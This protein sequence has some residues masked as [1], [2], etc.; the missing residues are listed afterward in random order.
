MSELDTLHRRLVRAERNVRRLGALLLLGTAT[1]LLGALQ[2]QDDVLRARG[3]IITD[4]DGRERIVLGAPMQAASGNEKLVDAVGIA[5]LDSLGRLHVAMGANPPLVLDGGAI[6]TR[7]ATQAGMTFYDPR[8]G[9]ERG[10]MGAFSDGRAT[11]CL[12]YGAAVKEATCMFVAPDDAYASVIVNAGP[13]QEVFDLV[14]MVVAADGTG[15]LKA[16]GAGS[17]AS[18]VLIKAGNG[19]ATITV[20]DSSGT[21]VRELARP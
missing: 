8:S 15:V 19:P 10:G 18:H 11:A 4:A 2:P 16:S 12:D 3:L 1:V 14:T 5:V 21:V 7:V 20:H 9:R 17:E 13:S 6:G